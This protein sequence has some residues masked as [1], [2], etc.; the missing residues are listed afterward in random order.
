MVAEDE[1][2]IK[3]VLKN[4][5]VFINHEHRIPYFNYLD[6]KSTYTIPDS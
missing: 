4:I 1:Y 6:S 2:K 5:C 3:E